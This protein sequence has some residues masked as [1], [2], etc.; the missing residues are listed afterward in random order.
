[1]ATSPQPPRPPAP[2]QPPG[3]RSH[4]VAIVLLILALIVLVGGI[5]VWVGAARSFER[6]P[7]ASGEAGRREERGLHQNALGL[8]RGQPGCE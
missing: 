1:M 7:R 8:A 2:P 5:G 4:I 3:S 6:R